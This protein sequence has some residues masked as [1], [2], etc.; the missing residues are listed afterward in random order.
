MNLTAHQWP[1]PWNRPELWERPAAEP[2]PIS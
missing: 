2:G 1:E